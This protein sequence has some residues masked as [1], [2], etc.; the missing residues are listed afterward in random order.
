MLIYKSSS[1]FP[2][3]LRPFKNG[4]IYKQLFKDYKF[5]KMNQIVRNMFG[6]PTDIHQSSSTVSLS[7]ASDPHHHFYGFGNQDAATN[8]GL[9]HGYCIWTD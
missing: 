1:I 6:A 4:W 8:S 9:S 3:Q 5:R 7:R 2:S